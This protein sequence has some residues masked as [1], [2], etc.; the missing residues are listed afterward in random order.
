MLPLLTPALEV[1]I[2]LAERIIH[3]EKT[4]LQ[5]KQDF[6][7]EVLKPLYEDLEPLASQYI[8]FFRRAHNEIMECEQGDLLKIAVVLKTER[9]AL[10]MAR[11]KVYA[12]SRVIYERLEGDNTGI[13][14]FIDAIKGF[15]EDNSLKRVTI[16]TGPATNAWKLISLFD[17]LGTGN[18]TR[19]DLIKFIDLTFRSMETNWELIVYLYQE[20]KLNLVMNSNKYI[21]NSRSKK[22]E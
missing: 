15:F 13:H 1:F 22:T 5:E 14:L 20:Q 21:K 10:V 3:L 19:K 18:L 12:M 16:Q 2:K 7:N 11:I 17:D 6:F 8:A 4:K 9:D